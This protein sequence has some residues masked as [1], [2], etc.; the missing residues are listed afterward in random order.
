MRAI[1]AD[2][3]GSCAARARNAMPSTESRRAVITGM[4]LVSPLGTT[5]ETAWD[6]LAAGRSGVGPLRCL[7]AENLSIRCAGE[8]REF[9]GRDLRFWTVGKGAGPDDPQGVEGDVPRDSNGR[10]SRPIGDAGCGIEGRWL[11]CRSHRRRLWFGLYHDGARGIHGR[12]AE[13][14]D[15]GRAVRL[16][17]LGDG[18]NAKSDSLMAAQVPAEHAG[19][20]RCDLQRLARAQ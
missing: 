13:L 20:S 2:S 16:C 8:V 4:G 10:G 15:A 9:F 6:A 19:Q 12:R 5:Q 14:P 7:P 1:P 3:E 17:A 11:R 18:W